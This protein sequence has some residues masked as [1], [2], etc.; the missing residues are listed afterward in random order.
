M[1]SDR[2]TWPLFVGYLA[3]ALT[4]CVLLRPTAR[5]VPTQLG[6]GSVDRVGEFRFY[7]IDR[8]SMILSAPIK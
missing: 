2:L 6:P 7:P 1:G 3:V 4:L 8:A 5:V